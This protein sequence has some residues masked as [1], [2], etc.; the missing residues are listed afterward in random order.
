MQDQTALIRGSNNSTVNRIMGKVNFDAGDKSWKK[1]PSITLHLE[2]IYGL[3]VSDK[4]HTV[5]YM[6]FFSKLDQDVLER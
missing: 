2:F 4:R 6:H 5:M 3:L 1:P